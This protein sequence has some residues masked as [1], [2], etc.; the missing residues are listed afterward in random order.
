[1]IIFLLKSLGNV[2]KIFLLFKN[3]FKCYLQ[4]FYSNSIKNDYNLKIKYL[5]F[6]L[7]MIF[8]NP[9]HHFQ[10]PL[11]SGEKWDSGDMDYN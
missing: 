3:Y 10:T 4:K 7:K 2:E 11:I 1:M 9:S 8:Q 5:I 6:N